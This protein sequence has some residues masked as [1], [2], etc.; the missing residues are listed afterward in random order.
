LE[1]ADFAAAQ[2]LL[3]LKT[4]HAYSIENVTTE[5]GQMK[6]SLY[7]AQRGLLQ[8]VTIIAYY[9][10]KKTDTYWSLAACLE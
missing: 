9:Y 6:R 10:E 1:A 3:D 4:E 8:G 7:Q 2:N 5:N